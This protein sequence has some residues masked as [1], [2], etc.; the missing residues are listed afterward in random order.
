MKLSF[1]LSVHPFIH[2]PV[3]SSRPHVPHASV[4]PSA[5]DAVA[6]TSLSGCGTLGESVVAVEPGDGRGR[7]S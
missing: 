3:S 2:M 4:S 1:F 5:R 6:L 7:Q